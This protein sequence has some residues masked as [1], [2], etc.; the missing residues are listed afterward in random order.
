MKGAPSIPFVELVRDTIR[1]HGLKFAVQY[2]FK[3]LPAW[4]ARFFITQAYLGA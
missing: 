1:V 2:Y 4:E 3:R